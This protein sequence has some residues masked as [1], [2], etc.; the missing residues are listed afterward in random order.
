MDEDKVIIVIPTY[1]EALSIE[2]LIHSIFKL[3]PEI[4]ALIVDDNSPDGTF[5]KADQLKNQYPNLQIHLRKTK[6]GLGAAYKNAFEIIKQQDRFDFIIQMDADLSHDPNDLKQLLKY[7][8]KNTMVIGSRYNKGIRVSNWHWLRVSISR[9]ANWYVQKA[10]GIPV[11]DI[12]SGFNL[13]P[14]KHLDKKFL[15]KLKSRHY[16]FQIELKYWLWKKNVKLVEAPIT[17]HERSVG[18]SKFNIYLFA[19]AFYLTLLIRFK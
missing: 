10:L 13:I 9:L 15:S 7:K 16:S 17:F 6:Q 8:S 11:Q 5:N 4:S 2:E 12:T 19:E 1:N 14:T 3:Y 18:K